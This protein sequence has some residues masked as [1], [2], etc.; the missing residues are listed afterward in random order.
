MRQQLLQEVED[1]RKHVLSG[2]IGW[3]SE[4]GMKL[5]EAGFNRI[6]NSIKHI[7][8]EDN[9]ECMEHNQTIL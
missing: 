1:T 8:S 3:C 6:E 9:D 4:E 2:L 7:C 5:V